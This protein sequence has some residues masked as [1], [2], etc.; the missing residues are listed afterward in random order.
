MRLIDHL[1]VSSGLGLGNGVVI[2][3]TSVH[4]L[5]ANAQLCILHY[6]GPFKS[7]PGYTAVIAIKFVGGLHCFLCY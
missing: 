5:W 3:C 2:G 6:L 4:W 1:P 7:Y